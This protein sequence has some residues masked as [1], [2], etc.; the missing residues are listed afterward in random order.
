MRPLLAHQGGWD[1]MLLAAALVLAMLGFSRYRR[2]ERGRGRPP[3]PS[4]DPTLCAYCGGP[5]ESSDDRCRTCGFR[6]ARPT[7]G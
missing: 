3:P 6:I 5:I 4:N 1:E 7:T 2:R